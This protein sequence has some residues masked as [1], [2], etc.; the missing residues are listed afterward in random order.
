[1][2]QLSLDDTVARPNPNAHMFDREGKPRR[3]LWC[4]DA[5]RMG[6][7]CPYVGGKARFRPFGGC[8]L[9]L[10]GLSQ[11]QI[12]ERVIAERNAAA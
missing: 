7:G 1:M 3:L 11:E 8:C 5:A 12:D 10:V 6:K 2:T 9:D 4:G